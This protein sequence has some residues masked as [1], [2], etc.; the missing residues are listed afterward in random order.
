MIMATCCALKKFPIMNSTFNDE[1]ILVYDSVNIGIAVSLPQ[2]LI[3]P[4]LKNADKKRLYEIIHE[5][6]KLISKA[7]EGKLTV[8]DVVGGTFT[9]S[10]IS[11]FNV[12][13]GTPI[14]RRPEN[15]IIAFGRIKKK[16]A[17]YRDQIVIRSMMV[18][19]LTFDHRAIDG[20]PASQFLSTLC[21]YFEN[22]YL[23][24]L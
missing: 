9:I 13:G 12:D 11:M 3:V 22:P 15:G 5:R 24:L 21:K 1:E 7:R 20:A 6:Q 2:G 16:P 14:L 10:N 23:L 17:V 19:S 8:E 4:V 18:V